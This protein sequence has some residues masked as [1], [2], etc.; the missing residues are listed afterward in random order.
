MTVTCYFCGDFFRKNYELQLHFPTHTNELPHTC[1]MGCKVF[2]RH[3][4]GLSRHM[5]KS[6]NLTLADKDNLSHSKKTCY[7]CLEEFER[8][9]LLERHLLKIHTFERPFKCTFT[10]CNKS[11]LTKAGFKVHQKASCEFNPNYSSNKAKSVD[12]VAKHVCYFFMKGFCLKNTLYLHLMIHLLENIIKCSGCGIKCEY[13][14]Y[15]KH[16]SKCVK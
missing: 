8:P 10:N 1:R 9:Y 15:M 2:Y 5:L 4:S 6:H 7:F 3:K 13:I 14:K 11:F 12:S 16:L